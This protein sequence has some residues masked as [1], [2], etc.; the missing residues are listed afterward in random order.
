MGYTLAI[1]GQA[2]LN[3]NLIFDTFADHFRLGPLDDEGYYTVSDETMIDDVDLLLAVESAEGA[4][5]LDALNEFTARAGM[6]YTLVIRSGVVAKNL[7]EDAARVVAVQDVP[8][9][10]AQML[11]D[12]LDS[13]QEAAIALTVEPGTPDESSKRLFNLLD[14]RAAAFS[15]GE[16]LLPCDPRDYLTDAQIAT[17]ELVAEFEAEHGPISQEVPDEARRA[18]G[19]DEAGPTSSFADGHMLDLLGFLDA[20]AEAADAA[21]SAALTSHG[22]LH[23]LVTDLRSALPMPQ[24][25]PPDEAGGEVKTGTSWE[26]LRAEMDFTPDE[27]AEI[28]RIGEEQLAAVRA[29]AA[30]E[31]IEPEEPKAR[32]TKVKREWKDPA[33]GEWKPMGRGRP[34]NNVEVREV[35][36]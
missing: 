2:S 1:F 5:A 3:K 25:A 32:P 13:G 34:R 8:A 23:Q 19:I 6:N 17:K 24:E 10:I 29:E 12:A 20:I 14:A 27:E 22:R 35:S 33:T 28:E 18:L 26:Q 4:E 21:M 16:G 30:P 11:L 9:K 15:I 31:P 7:A 36:A